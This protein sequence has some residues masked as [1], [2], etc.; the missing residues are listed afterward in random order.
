V[1]NRNYL[2]LL[3][4]CAIGLYA[5]IIYYQ[6][7][8]QERIYRKFRGAIK[9]DL[10][11]LRS[12][13]MT[14]NSL[15]LENLD[16]ALSQEDYLAAVDQLEK[17]IATDSNN[18]VLKYYTAI[19]HEQQENYQK[20]IEHYQQVRFNSEIFCLEALKRLSLLYIRMHQNDRAIE[21]LTELRNLGTSVEKKWAED[22]AD[23]LIR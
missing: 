17:M 14:K 4:V 10:P 13:S 19:L 11:N 15:A 3:T 21:M 22:V 16:I 23:A 6:S 2:V 8:D 20:S 7:N 12:R 1:A 9:S 18:I 5:T